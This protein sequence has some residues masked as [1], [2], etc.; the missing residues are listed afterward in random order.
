MVMVMAVLVGVLGTPA[1]S[2]WLLAQVPGLQVEQFSGR[3][4]GH[5]QAERLVWQQGADRVELKGPVV[6]WSPACL[7][8]LTLCVQRLDIGK[9]SLSR[10]L[11]TATDSPAAPSR[12]PD[13]GLPLTLVLDEV[14]VGRLLVDGQEQAR[15]LSARGRW[16]AAGLQVERLSAQRDGMALELQG[17]LDPRGDWPLDAQGSLTVPAPDAQP[18]TVQ[19]A[20]QGPLQGQ[21]QVTAD[22]HGYLQGRLDGELQP[23]VKA[24]P[25][26]LN[27]RL[28]RLETEVPGAGPLRLEQLQLSAEGD[29]QAGYQLDG[30][31]Q[32]PAQGAALALQLRGRVT[33]EGAQLAALS[34]Q[35]GPGERLQLS[36]ELDWQDGV[37]A[38]GLLDWQDFPWQRLFPAVQMPAVALR[39]LNAEAHYRDGNYLGNFDA[40]LDGPAGPFSLASPVSG[41]LT[42]VHLP[43]L[44]LQAGQGSAQGN[45]TLG[46]A[47]GLRWSTRL[48]LSALDPAYWLAE[49]PGALEGTLS[50]QGHFQTGQL[51][52]SAQLDL[53]GRLRGQPAVVRLQG[54]GT[55]Q[56][57]LLEQLELRLGDNRLDGQVRLDQGLTGKLRLRM[58]RLGQLWP[59]LAGYLDGRVDLAGSLQAP[60]GRL[61]LKGRDLALGQQRLAQL[62]LE[63][64]VDE[65]GRGQL[66][67]DGQGIALGDN[68]WGDL[69]LRAEG[70][71]RRQAL[72]VKLQGPRLK[73]EL[74]LAGTL[75][76][77]AW[78]GQLNRGQLSAGDQEWRLQQSAPLRRSAEGQLSLGSQCWRAGSASLC[79]QA[80]PLYPHGK[81]AY[82]LQAF[83]LD[84]LAGLLPA[85]LAWQGRLDGELRLD[86]ADTGPRGVVRLDAGPGVLRLRDRQQWL[87]F[88]YQRLEL[89][90]RLEPGQIDSR[91]TFQGDRLGELSVQVQVDPRA[92]DKPLRGQFSLTGLDLSLARPFVEG[93][94]TLAGQLNGSGTLS[95]GLLAP[96]VDGQLS[97]SD[98]E[99]SGGQ[100]PLSIEAL[101]V[102]ARI[103]GERVQLDGDWRSGE[104]GHGQLTGH[105]NWVE[106][107]ALQLRVS[108]S[109]LPVR[110]EP[111]ATLEVEPQLDLLLENQR[112]VVHGRVAVPRGQI[113]VRQLPPSTVTLSKD[114]VLVGTPSEQAKTPLAIGMDI[115]V[116]VGQERLS[117]EGFGLNA[118]LVGRLRIGDNL[119][120]RGE[121]NL[122]NG[123]YRAYGQRLSLRRARLLFVGPIDQPYLDIEAIRR[124]DEVVAGLRLSGNAARPSSQVFSE[125]AMSQEQALSY[126]VLGRPLN[127]SGGDNDLLGQAALAMGLA[128]S[129]SF[130]GGLAQRLGIRDFELDSEGS[131]QRTSLVA[132]G[133]LSE[134]LSLR[135]G[136]GV[137]E[138][139]NSLAL[140]YELSKRLYL[141]AASGL[142]S[143]LD[144]FYKRDF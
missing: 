64:R 5:W 96:R 97:L 112:L 131:G 65:G 44:Q 122:R 21:L 83:P 90:S 85:D 11:L 28:A 37:A 46:F 31:A 126:L 69:R 116:E 67:L 132:S 24:L 82:R 29:M 118:D 19:L 58:P 70:D 77:G 105:L 95:G 78:S 62:S 6:Q 76:E 36:G 30:S 40:R 104:V 139:A 142:A 93:V 110:V 114:A 73:V 125:P 100:L 33:G 9:L 75:Q 26:R 87:A 133:K 1:G 16:S 17:S 136:V 25:A 66:T 74:G 92:A 63:A 12:L 143:S 124:V 22:S 52:A 91:L 130:S 53:H 45:L 54:E 129:A 141:E 98:G 84:G 13:L 35:G 101:Q 20:A 117:F 55:P 71:A 127:A 88:P 8:R 61:T 94:D 56:R 86:L 39:R 14:H 49:L 41:D 119:E 109:R 48:A 7:L 4:G 99:L 47:E 103:A 115:E 50:S 120:T 123:R 57:W 60:Q 102:Q 111:Y 121:L 135:Y 79:G 138:P 134:R 23:L 3:L 42:Q 72:E 10:R 59:G 18:W 32:L 43:S 81:L 68:A 128:G 140:R 2:R 106:G 27:L 107:L 144:I 80:Q 137:F 38:H 113:E 89:D 34:L 108:G 51:Q 15:A